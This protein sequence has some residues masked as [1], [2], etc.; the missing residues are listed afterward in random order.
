M[1]SVNFER[2]YADRLQ[3]IMNSNS[4]FKE[5]QATGVLLELLNFLG[6]EEVVKNFKVLHYKQEA[7]KSLH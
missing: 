5:V 1:T 6:Y 2:D 7:E 4:E 3:E